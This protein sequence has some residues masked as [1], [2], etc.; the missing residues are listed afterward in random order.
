DPPRSHC[1]GHYPTV[2]ARVADHRAHGPQPLLFSQ[3][4]SPRVNTRS[5]NPSKDKRSRFPGK[6]SSPAAGTNVV[7][8]QDGQPAMG[9]SGSGVSNSALSRSLR[10]GAGNP[11][12]SG[13]S[14]GQAPVSNAAVN[15]PLAA[16][17]TV[18]F[19]PDVITAKAPAASGKAEA[20]PPAEKGNV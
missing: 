16:G 1:R 5:M 11:P 9:Q 12:V 8:T 3:P 13:S 20:Q 19:A 18:Q 10:N 17:P 14:P 7:A 15:S 4:R 6:G 2:S